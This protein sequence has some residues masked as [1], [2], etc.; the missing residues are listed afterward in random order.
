M[1]VSRLISNCFIIVCWFIIVWLSV[2]CSWCSFG[3]R[4][5]MLVVVMVEF[6]GRRCG[7]EVGWVVGGRINC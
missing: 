1:L 2:L 5:L 3:R 6:V 4:V 7:V